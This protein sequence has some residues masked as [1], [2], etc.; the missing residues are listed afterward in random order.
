MARTRSRPWGGMGM[1]CRLLRRL[2]S[3]RLGHSKM[4]GFRS[5]SSVLAVHRFGL[6]SN[7]QDQSSFPVSR[8]WTLMKDRSGRISKPF[9]CFCWTIMFKFLSLSQTSSW[10]SW[11]YG[12]W[13]DD[14]LFVVGGRRMILRRQGMLGEL[15]WCLMLIWLVGIGWR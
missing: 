11:W 14:T 13:V 3:G 12:A 8:R 5:V 4:L 9:L 7:L 6:W 1:G 2:L 10:S 15:G